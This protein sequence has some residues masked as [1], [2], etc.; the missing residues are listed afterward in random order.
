MSFTINIEKVKDFYSNIE[1]DEN[2]RYKSWEHCYNYF[3]QPEK[4]IEV[5]K[6]CLHLSFYLA[7]SSMYGGPSYLLQKDYFI[8][9]DLIKNII[10]NPKYKMLQEW[11]F[12]KENKINIK[13]LF[14]LRNE[15]KEYY[16]NK[17]THINGERKTVNVSAEL[18]TKIIL[19]TFGCVPVYDKYFIQGI[20]L[21][22]KQFGLKFHNK[23]F[24]MTFNKKGFLNIIKVYQDN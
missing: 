23:Q 1:N 21:H 5:D 7:S 11:D 15:I 4:D 2:H 14:E 12:L 3:L 6:A 24:G 22:D 10:L 19:G 13:Y 17:I 18:S 20:K 9:K 8:H 16:E